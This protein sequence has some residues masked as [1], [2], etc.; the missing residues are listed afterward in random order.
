MDANRIQI[1]D[2]FEV[3]I[4]TAISAAAFGKLLAGV[5]VFSVVW[6]PTSTTFGTLLVAGAVPAAMAVLA[7]GIVNQIAPNGGFLKL[8]ATPAAIYFGLKTVVWLTGI[9]LQTTS[10][11][12]ALATVG[13][14]AFTVLG[15]SALLVWPCPYRIHPFG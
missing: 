14:I 8:L 15:V 9:S 3:S 11:I 10:A 6:I 7:I 5:S 4:K 12:L 13:P 1:V 2:V